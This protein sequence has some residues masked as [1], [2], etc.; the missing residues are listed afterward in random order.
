MTNEFDVEPDY[1]IDLPPL[2]TFIPQ[3]R[4]KDKSTMVQDRIDP[5]LYDFE[6]EVEPI[7]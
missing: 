5:D 7:L 2:A 3:A 6:L 4:G 1:F